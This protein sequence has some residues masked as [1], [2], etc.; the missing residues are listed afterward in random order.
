VYQVQTELSVSSVSG[1]IAELP[2]KSEVISGLRDLLKNG[3]EADKCNAS[4]ALGNIGAAEAVDDLVSHL[5]DE[6]VDVCIDAAEALGRLRAHKVVPQ[7]LESLKNDPDGELKTTIVK[8][9][10]EIQN[11]Q[12]IPLLLQIAESQ[13]EDMIM[14]SNEDWDDWWDMQQQAIIALGN[15]RVEQATDMLARLLQSDD[16]LDI[17]QDI[18]KAL[19]R[20]GVKGEAAVIEQLT[21][22]SAQTRRRA[23]LAL[24]ESSSA[25]SLKALAKALTDNSE[26]VRLYALQALVKR[27]A[28]KYLSAIELLKRD[29]S[30]KVRQAALLAIAE[31]SALT[32]APASS[33]NEKLLQDPDSEVRAAYLKTL[34]NQQVEISDE[35]L[36][37]HIDSALTDSDEQVMLAALPLFAR[38][39]DSAG[40]ETRLIQLIAQPKL[41]DALLT[42]GMQTLS[43][44]GR[45]NVNISRLM[46]RF[47][48][49]PQQ[50]VRLATLK[51][52]MDMEQTLA[53]ADMPEGMAKTPVD[54][55]N[56][57]LSGRVVLEVEVNS[58]LETASKNAADDDEEV[59]AVSDEEISALKDSAPMSTLEA[60]MQ[61]SQLAELEMQQAQQQVIEDED[62]EQDAEMAE[63]E[64]LVER[65]N[66]RADWLFNNKGEVSVAQDV[67]RLSARI[68]ARLPKDIAPEKAAKIVNSLLFALN[69][70]DLQLQTLAAES[71]A[72]IALDNPQTEGIEY[73][74]GGLVT[75]FHNEQWDLKLACM[76][77]LAAI[78]NRAA[79]P[80]IMNALDHHRAALRIQAIES[81]TD[82]ELNGD[83]LLKNA[84]VPEKPLTLIE[85]VELLIEK[86]QD[87]EPG[88]RY[89][90]VNN[91][92][93]CLKDKTIAQDATLVQKAIEH[94]VQTAFTN[95]GGRTRDM[96]QVL[97]EI[98]PVKGT[99]RL[100][101]LLK[102]LP[103][104]Y[105]R[106]FAIEMLEEMFKAETSRMA[107]N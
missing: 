93:R 73:A 54:I 75:Q 4:R 29:R 17:E 34:H 100:I 66:T 20:I 12:A 68:L 48:S 65:N 43:E 76:K 77:A 102:E 5:H 41:S 97:K 56:E 35:E 64:T 10:G 26:D 90:A 21:S 1:N 18:L 36:H 87:S 70:E 37:Q 32:G 51:A 101:E 74:F 49:H 8:A 22:A 59:E 91:L 31:L 19:V 69:S 15:M 7:L 80:V 9:L 47:I 24:I 83:E 25:E 28:S 89:S 105:Q 23:A 38:L 60:I 63:F 82:L 44:L 104:S 55:V 13:P 6:D 72:Q 84:H 61:E 40:A 11:E 79:I 88:V 57:T 52:L 33:A 27:K 106:R 67:Q 50:T 103:S 96:A 98:E 78:R 46:T 14:D 81:I 99:A 85:W 45:W 53:E 16:V 86:L 39:Q 107:L 42:A 95:Q 3:D 92:K 94:I 62:I 58:L 71:I 30:E 2:I